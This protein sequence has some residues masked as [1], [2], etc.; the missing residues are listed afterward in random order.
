MIRKTGT[1]VQRMKTVDGLMT[2]LEE[3][4][5]EEEEETT[6]ITETDPA[7][8]PIVP[9]DT[10]DPERLRGKGDEE[11]GSE[12]MEINNNFVFHLF[13]PHIKFKFKMCTL[14]ILLLL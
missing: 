11:G 3:G 13:L 2:E 14:K 12:M 8:I 6:I 10:Q 1:P 9:P 7:G 4:E 5:L